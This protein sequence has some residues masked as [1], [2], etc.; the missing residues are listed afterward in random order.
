[1][2]T[3]RKIFTVQNLT[4]KFKEAKGLVLTDYRGLNVE[5][6]NELRAKVKKVGGQFEV[7]KNTLLGLAAQNAK[8]KIDPKILKEPTGVL[9]LDKNTLKPLKAFFQFIQATDSPKVKFGLLA[10]VKT[11]VERLKELASLPT[12]EELQARLVWILRSPA[13]SL[14]NALTWN[15]KKLLFVLKNIKGGEKDG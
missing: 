14:V 15:Q 10:G 4:E 2:P 3:Q 6:I 7:V 9:W 12:K 13:Y 1:M 5:Q 8:T 11:S